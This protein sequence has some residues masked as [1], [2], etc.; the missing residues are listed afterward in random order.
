MEVAIINQDIV[1]V[2][3]QRVEELVQAFI[4]SQ[5]VKGSSKGTYYRTLK[6]YFTWI[7]AKG[8]NLATVNRVTILEYKEDLLSSGKSS[9]SVG[10]YITS[11]RRFY[12]WAEAN[13]FYPN[14]AKGVKSPKRK[15]QFKKQ[16]LLPSQ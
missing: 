13:K 8:Y 1:G 4:D 11:V 6:Q 3:S 10:S 12:E 16:P 14:I 5:D 9:L 15:Q 7:S 2:N